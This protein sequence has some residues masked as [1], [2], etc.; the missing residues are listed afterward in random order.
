MAFPPALLGRLHEKLASE[1]FDAGA[2]FMIE[3]IDDPA[4]AGPW[5]KRRV[6]ATV[7]LPAES[8]CWL[9][10]H[11]WAFDPR[12]ARAQLSAHP[13]L[14]LRLAAMLGLDADGGA[15]TPAPYSYGQASLFALGA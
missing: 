13:S 4:V 12:D 5:A 15:P 6:V 14:L 1:V 2:C 11:A 8:D 3:L 7:D 10:D 9:V